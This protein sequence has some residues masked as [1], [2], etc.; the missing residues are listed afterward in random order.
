M[1]SSKRR[2][3]ILWLSVVGRHP[4][5]RLEYYVGRSSSE[6]SNA[7]SSVR[8]VTSAISDRRLHHSHGRSQSRDRLHASELPSVFL[9]FA[10]IY[11]IAIT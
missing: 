8:T 9:T 3:K 6:E 4:S 2:V 5:A 10:K 1:F 7:R 11:R